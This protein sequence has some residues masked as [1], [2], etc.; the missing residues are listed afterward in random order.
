MGTNVRHTWKEVLKNKT[1]YLFISPFYLLFLVFGLFPILFSAYLAVNKWD[2]IGDLEYVGF[3]QFQFLFKDPK[4]YDAVQNTFTIW[5]MANIPLLCSALVFAFLINLSIVRFKD[6]YRIA[7]YLPNVTAMVAVVIIFQSFFGN[8]YGFANYLLQK[9]GLNEVAWLNHK[10][11]VQFIIA[12]MIYWRFLGYNMIIYLA[13]LQ[14]IPNDLYEA[15]KIDG[16]TMYDT[17]SKITIPMLRPII[18]FTVMMST[19]G[20]L[21]I[22]T[23]PQV[24]ATLTS[25]YPG[26]ETIV[27]YLFRE[28]FKYN[29]YG[30]AAA[31]S[32]VMFAI[33]MVISFLNWKLFKPADDR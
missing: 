1:L 25:P 15:A 4:F 30:Y 17:F 23:E 29:N 13:G 6:F 9:I 2:G 24:L 21:Q 28:A 18:L 3:S 7:F 22:F 5:A 11:S 8:H 32:W 10:I 31:V 20:G 27:L 26:S 14:K 19:I 16:A 33:I 12:T